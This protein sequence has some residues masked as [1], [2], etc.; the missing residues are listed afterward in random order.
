MGLLDPIPT[1]IM[2]P[3]RFKKLQFELP[4]DYLKNYFYL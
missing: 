4:T 2:L 1:L 3:I